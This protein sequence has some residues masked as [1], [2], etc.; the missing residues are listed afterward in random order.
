LR[1]K[2]TNTGRAFW[3]A[4]RWYPYP[5]GSVTLGAYVLGPAQERQRELPRTTLPRSVS[6]GETVSVELRVAREEAGEGRLAVDMVREGVFWF[7]E[8]GSEPLVLPPAAV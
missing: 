4:G 5:N 8:A 1:L 7:S 3:P 2:V 6:P